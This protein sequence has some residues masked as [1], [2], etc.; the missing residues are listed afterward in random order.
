MQ[1]MDIAGAGFGSADNVH[2]LAEVLKIAFAD[3]AA[4][5]ADPAFVPVP[6]ERLLSAGYAAER[7][8]AFD[9]VCV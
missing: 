7:C 3:R 9:L 8:A 1:G 2:R 5:T 4:S 6:V